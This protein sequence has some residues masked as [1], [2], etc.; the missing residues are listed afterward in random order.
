LEL[1]KEKPLLADYIYQL[2][3]KTGSLTRNKASRQ[4]R[5]EL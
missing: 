5:A 3:S 1:G 2:K 4:G